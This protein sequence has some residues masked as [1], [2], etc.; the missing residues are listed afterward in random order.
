[1]DNLICHNGSKMASKFEKYHVSRLPH[2]LYTPEINPCDFWLFGMLRGVLK[3]C[4]F[5][6]SDDIEKEITK[7][8][9]EL[10]FDEVQSAFHN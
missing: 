10:N 7:V 5:N 1:M 6:L 4:D 2:S 8:W 9:D 3:N